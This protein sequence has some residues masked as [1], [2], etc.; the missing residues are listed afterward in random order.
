MTCK[1]KNVLSVPSSS[2]PPPWSSLSTSPTAQRAS[3]PGL[4]LWA[5]HTFLFG[6]HQ[7]RPFLFLF[8]FLIITV[9]PPLES[10]NAGVSPALIPRLWSRVIYP[11]QFSLSLFLPFLIITF[12]LCLLPPSPFPASYFVSLA[13]ALS[14]PFH[15]QPSFTLFASCGWHL[16]L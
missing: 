2:L 6:G 3:T 15:R 1:K 9:H 8:L 13:L 16:P 12:V 10:V 5:M 14:S 7:T 11:S 4:L